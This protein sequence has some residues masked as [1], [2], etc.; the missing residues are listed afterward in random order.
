MSDSRFSKI[1]DKL[2]DL[3]T[4]L[5]EL[6]TV[7]S[8]G[9]A[10]YNEQLKIHIKGTEDNRMAIKINTGEIE[11]LQDEVAP[12]QKQ[13]QTLQEDV[14]PIKKHVDFIKMSGKYFVSLLGVAALIGGLVFGVAELLK[15]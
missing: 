9:F 2:D 15:N 3:K 13:M 6:K 10:V 1:D 7:I 5:A 11:K 8:T 12:L 14:T 4:E